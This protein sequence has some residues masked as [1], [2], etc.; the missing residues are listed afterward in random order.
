M[1]TVIKVLDH[2]YV[3]FVEAFGH[4]K[5]GQDL[6]GY[7]YREHDY[8][9][10]IIEAARQSTQ[11]GFLGWGDAEHPGDEKLLRYLGSNKHTTPFEFAGMIIEV[12]APIFVFRE[13]FTHR[14]QSRSEMS[15]RYA[16]LPCIDYIPTI[17]RT[18]IGASNTNKQAGKIAGAPELTEESAKQWLIEL[19]GLYER[20]ED[21]YQ[22]GLSIGIPKELA[23]AAMP[24][25][26]YS[27]MRVQANLHNWLHF[28][29]LRTSPMAQFEI[30]QF[31]NAVADIVAENFPRTW[32]LFKERK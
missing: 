19:A 16:P 32:E 18:M 28:I 12:Q 11:K 29:S 30:R 2:G 26:R 13:W 20:Q 6:T 7:D 8:E 24:V 3:D 5:D 15:A 14:T 31:A 22:M 9:V 21:F 1:R 10:G 25:G 23:R 4:G 27:R 17:E